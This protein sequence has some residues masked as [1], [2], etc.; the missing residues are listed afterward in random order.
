M[1]QYDGHEIWIFFGLMRDPVLN[2]MTFQNELHLAHT[3]LS[4]LG[5]SYV[6]E[7]IFIKVY[8]SQGAHFWGSLNNNVFFRSR[9][10]QN[11]FY[12]LPLLC[13]GAT[14]QGGWACPLSSSTPPSPSPTGGSS[15]PKERFLFPTSPPSTPSTQPGGSSSNGE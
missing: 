15:T 9:K 4:C 8:V 13:R 7:V 14:F 12:Q 1:T 11:Q 10:P 6:F 2:R 5:M 3:L